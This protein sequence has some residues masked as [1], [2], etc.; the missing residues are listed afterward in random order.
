MCPQC[1]W[2]QTERWLGKQKARLLACDHD[3]A[4]F[5]I[6][7]ALN[8]L[9]LA[10]VTVMSQ[11]LCASGHDTLLELLGDAKYL[12]ATPGLIATLHTWT[13]TLLLHPHIHCVVTGGGLTDAGQ[14]VTVRHGFLLPM[15]V[16]MAVFRGKLLAAI[17]QGVPHGQLRPPQ[18]R[19]LQ[20]LENLLNKLGRQK[21]NV[22]IRERY[23]FQDNRHYRK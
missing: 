8:D 3:H 19:S 2:L 12:G 14:W 9:W 17:R 1:A 22:H 18:G 11:L 10:N 13:Q 7:H 20:Q 16:V 6:P 15:R 5:T 21:W 4:I 23:R